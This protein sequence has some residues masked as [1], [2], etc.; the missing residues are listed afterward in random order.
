[1]TA[2]HMSR[3][4]FSDP[5]KKTGTC[6][7]AGKSP[8]YPDL[9]AQQLG[10][11]TGIVYEGRKRKVVEADRAKRYKASSRRRAALSSMHDTPEAWEN[12]DTSGPSSPFE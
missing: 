7:N 5:S 1:M 12:R 8:D 4:I 6:Q 2:L 11:G 10:L 9:L 3:F